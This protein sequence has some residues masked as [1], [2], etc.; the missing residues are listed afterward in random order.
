LIVDT[1]QLEV[2]VTLT[3][4]MSLGEA[5]ALHAVLARGGD[6]TT[7]PLR[8]ALSIQLNAAHAALHIRSVAA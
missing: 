7:E 2:R 3:A 4:D 1:P 6:V 8:R 5:I